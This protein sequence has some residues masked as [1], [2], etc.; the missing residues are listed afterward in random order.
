VLQVS[1]L[2]EVFLFFLLDHADAGVVDVF[3]PA[4]YLV[5]L[6][7]VHHLQLHILQRDFAFHQEYQFVRNGVLLE[8]YRFFGPV[9][10]LVDRR[11]DVVTKAFEQSEL[12]HQGGLKFFLQVSLY[13]FAD[14]GFEAF[15]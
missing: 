8:Y 14:L 7:F 10:L 6:L 12:V 5:G 13:V 2:V 11:H 15:Q 4:D 9:V 3:S 1:I